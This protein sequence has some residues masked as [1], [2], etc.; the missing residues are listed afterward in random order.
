MVTKMEQYKQITTKEG[1]APSG[2]TFRWRGAT[3]LEIAMALKSIP[4]LNGAMRVED[5]DM[6]RAIEVGEAFSRFLLPA[7][8][9]EPRVVDSDESV[10]EDAIPF[11]VLTNEDVAW[12]IGK[13]RGSAKVDGPDADAARRAL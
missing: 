9:L 6:L 4:S 13:I 8:V 1:V 11:S 2:M 3:A 12:L 10:P 7:C 5:Q